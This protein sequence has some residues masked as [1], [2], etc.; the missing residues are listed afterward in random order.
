MLIRPERAQDFGAIRTLIDAAFA[1]APHADG[2]EADFAERLRAGPGYRPDL[3]LVAVIDGAVVA[4]LMLTG[5]VAEGRLGPV[6]LLMLAPVSVAPAWQRRG[7]GSHLVRA[8]LGCAVGAEGLVIVLGDPAYYGRFGFEAFSRFGMVNTNGFADRHTQALALRPGG[9][10][11]GCR[12]T[13]P[14]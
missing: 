4:H 13:F 1:D 3:A 11:T 5:L 14:T 10:W 9:D 7:V 6:R 2:D 8:G 12:V